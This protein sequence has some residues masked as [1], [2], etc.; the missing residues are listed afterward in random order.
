MSSV[1]SEYDHLHI[2]TPLTK[3]GYHAENKASHGQ[4]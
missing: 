3:K 2:S 4:K 1:A